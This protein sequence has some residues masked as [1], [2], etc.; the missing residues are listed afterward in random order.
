MCARPPSVTPR[1]FLE[2]ILGF[3]HFPF[4]FRDVNRVNLLIILQFPAHVWTVLPE[5]Y[6]SYDWMQG[7]ADTRVGPLLLPTPLDVNITSPLVSVE[8]YFALDFKDYASEG[9]SEAAE[10]EKASVLSRGG[11]LSVAPLTSSL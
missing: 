10:D 3:T 6:Q 2:P 7:L 8:G 1:I 4:E 5:G 9:G 11:H